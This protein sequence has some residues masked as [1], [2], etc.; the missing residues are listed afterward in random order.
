M[1]RPG[2]VP[3]LTMTTAS[4]RNHRRRPRTRRAQESPAKEAPGALAPGRPRNR[5]GPGKAPG[6][7]GRPWEAF[8]R[9][10]G[11]HGRP[12]NTSIFESVNNANQARLRFL[13]TSGLQLIIWRGLDAADAK[14]LAFDL[15]KNRTVKTVKYAATPRVFAFV[16][17]PVNIVC[18]FCTHSVER[19]YLGV[20]SGKAFAAVLKDTQLTN[21]K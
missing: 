7:P 8:K 10:R 12:F 17:A 14:L 3:D 16:S 21:L 5:P 18:L 4:I 6:A 15:S 1:C 13:A 11:K 19:N 9:A 20:E 2:T